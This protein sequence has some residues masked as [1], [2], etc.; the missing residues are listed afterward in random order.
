MALQSIASQC[1][2]LKVLVLKD[3]FINDAIL[4]DITEYGFE[5]HSLNL[6]GNQITDIG[7]EVVIQKFLLLS[8]LDISSNGRVNVENVIKCMNV[9]NPILQLIM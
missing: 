9:N 1:L 7:L 6:K 3:C 2:F 8:E 5:L 4:I